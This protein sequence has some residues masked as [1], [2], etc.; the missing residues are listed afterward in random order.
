MTDLEKARK[1]MSRKARPDWIANVAAALKAER[2]QCAKIAESM[3][4]CYGTKIAA[5]IRARGEP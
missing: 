5:A 3:W 4:N 1:Y 2:E